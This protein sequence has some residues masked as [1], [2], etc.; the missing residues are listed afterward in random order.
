MN[1][2]E[3]IKALKEGKSVRVNFD[4]V[5]WK[6]A[7]EE[8]EVKSMRNNPFFN[9]VFD[10]LKNEHGNEELTKL[11][12]RHSALTEELNKI[13]VRITTLFKIKEDK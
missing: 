13:L 2:E 11:I 4:D 9:D 12:S 7:E 3:A 5:D 10:M 1:F 8:K 6:V